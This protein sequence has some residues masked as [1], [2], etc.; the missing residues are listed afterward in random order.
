MQL[1]SATK[2]ISIIEM[3]LS[4]LHHIL[5]CYFDVQP[6]NPLFPTYSAT[7]LVAKM[8]TNPKEHSI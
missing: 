2:F 7:I 4:D 6:L 5:Q 8:W 3:D 1:I